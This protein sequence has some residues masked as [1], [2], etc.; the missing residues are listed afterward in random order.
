M[1]RGTRGFTLIEL[2]VVIAIIAILMG[3][4]MPALQRA[5]EQGQ[6][7]VCMGTLKQ[8]TLCWIMYADAN[9]DKLINGEAGISYTGRAIHAKEPEW[10]GRCWREPYNS[11]TGT[12]WPI[13]GGNG[14]KAAIMGGSLWSY[15][16]SFGMYACPT[17]I[18]GEMLTYNLMDGVNG[19]ARAGTFN[20]TSPAMGPNGKQLWVK[21]RSN[22]HEPTYRIC[23]IDEGASTP[24]SFAVNWNSSVTTWWD[25]PPTRHGD[26]TVVSFVDGHVEHHKWKAARTIDYGRTY[27][28]YKGPGFTASTPEELNDI[29]F[30][31]KGC[32]GQKHS[33]FPSY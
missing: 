33:S 11:P 19:M 3:I 1:N 24:D 5:R 27:A 9:D 7:A 20:G 22:V 31:H 2:L 28:N 15:T 10:V 17:G 18:R 8:L 21:K 16:Q 26:G 14:Q 6:R 13:E 4:L 12:Q 23:F 29:E 30:I 25:D 32:W